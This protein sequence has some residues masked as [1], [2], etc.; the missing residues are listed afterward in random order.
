MRR[1]AFR[2]DGNEDEIVDPE[3]D[4]KNDKREKTNPDGRIKKEFHVQLR[5]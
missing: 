4:F 1:E 2:D 3:D 5:V